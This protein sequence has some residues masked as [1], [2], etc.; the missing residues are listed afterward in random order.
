MARLAA[1]DDEVSVSDVDPVKQVGIRELKN[2]LSYYVRRAKAGQGI[3][4]TNRGEP[5]AE[6]IPP[7]RTRTGTTMRQRLEEL[8]RR[9]LV[10][11][12][13]PHD[14]SIYRRRMPRLVPDGT[15]KRLIDE[16]RRDR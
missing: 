6:L 9:G 3:Q 13:A 2:R 5:V 11:L 7:R 14:P 1:A 15:A 16:I 8:A 4:I 12:G 10:T